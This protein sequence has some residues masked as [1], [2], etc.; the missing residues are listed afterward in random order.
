MYSYAC[1]TNVYSVLKQNFGTCCLK[2]PASVNNIR[3]AVSSL[4]MRCIV[5]L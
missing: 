1:F 5:V 3:G 2:F 4:F